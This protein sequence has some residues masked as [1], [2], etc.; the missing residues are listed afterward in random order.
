VKVF[1]VKKGFQT[2]NFTGHRGLIVKLSF[3]SDP[4]SLTLFSSAED[5]Q[6]RV[7][8]LALST[9]VGQLEKVHKGVVSVFAF[10]NDKQTL[11]TGGR[12]GFVAFWSIK[13]QYQFIA[14]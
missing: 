5:Q 13:K 11:I 12:D 7:W 10:T 2:H 4:D 8:D 1:D 14:K 3:S 6:V 9:Q